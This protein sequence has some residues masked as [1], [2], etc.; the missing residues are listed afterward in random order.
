MLVLRNRMLASLVLPPPSPLLCKPTT[1]GF[2]LPTLLS[3]STRR[4]NP[5]QNASSASKTT[6]SPPM[7]DAARFVRTVL[8]VPP[9]VEP[10]EVTDEMVLPGS[11]IVVGPYAGDARIREVEFMKSSPRAKDC[12]KDGRPEFAILGRSNVGKSSL[13]NALVR[14]KEVALTS[15]KPGKTQLINHFLVNKSWYIVDLPGYG[16]AKAPDAAQMNWSAFTKGYFLNRD[17]LVAVLLLIDASVPPQKIDLDCANW[18]GRNNIP[19]T[20][21]F[22]K[23]DKMKAS[24]GKRPDENIRDFQQLIK[25]NYRQHPAWIMTS[26]V[27]GLGRDELLRH[28]SQLRNYWDQ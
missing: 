27:T 21:V 15:K 17:T 13:I 18:L 6:Q 28:M 1:F 26:S 3:H 19:M 9:G 12:P 20:F 2:C 4:R 7:A 11:N 8:F 25:Q 10:D 23:C 22:T 24:K 5:T 16:F 14:K